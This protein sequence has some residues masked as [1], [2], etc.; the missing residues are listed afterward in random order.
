MK[1]FIFKITFI[2]FFF[3]ISNAQCADYFTSQIYNNNGAHKTNSTFTILEKLPGYN[4]EAAKKKQ[5][6][7][8]IFIIIN[9]QQDPCGEK[10]TGEESDELF[11]RQLTGIHRTGG[12]S[13]QVYLPHI[14]NSLAGTL[15]D[16]YNDNSIIVDVLNPKYNWEHAD[17]LKKQTEF[18]LRDIIHQ[19]LQNKS[20]KVNLFITGFSRG[21]L[22]S[23]KLAQ[24]LKNE[25]NIKA[26]VTIDPVINPLSTDKKNIAVTAHYKPRYKKWE[27]TNRKLLSWIKPLHYF[28]VLKNP[29]VP[30]YN[31]FQRHGLFSFGG[32]QFGRPVGSAIEGAL[33]PCK[34]D[35]ICALFYGDVSKHGPF[36]QYDS[37]VAY[38]S[39]DMPQKY[40]KWALGI[41]LKTMPLPEVIK[42]VV[43][44]KP[45]KPII[46][47]IYGRTSLYTGGKLRLYWRPNQGGLEYQH[48]TTRIGQQDD[49]SDWRE[50]EYSYTYDMY[51]KGHYI[52]KVRARNKIGNISPIKTIMIKIKPRPPYF[53]YLRAS[54]R[55]G[56]PGMTIVFDWKASPDDISYKIKFSQ[57]GKSLL[58][59]EK[60]YKK[61]SYSTTLYDQGDYVFSIQA[62]TKEGT[63][64]RRYTRALTI[65]DYIYPDEV[66]IGEAP[67]NSPS[68]P[69]NPKY[70]SGTYAVAKLAHLPKET[71]D[72]Y[73]EG[74]YSMNTP[75]WERDKIVRGLWVITKSMPARKENLKIGQTIVY[76]G[77]NPAEASDVRGATMSL[78]FIDDLSQI[79]NNIVSAS[80]PNIDDPS[81]LDKKK[82]YLHNIRVCIEPKNCLPDTRLPIS[83]PKWSEL[84]L[85][86]YKGYLFN[87]SSTLKSLKT[88]HLFDQKLNTCWAEDANDSGIGEVINFSI[89][90]KTVKLNIANGYQK[91]EKLFYANNR[92]K[93]IKYQVLLGINQEGEVSETKSLCHTIALNK[94]Q[95]VSLEDKMGVQSVNLK[96]NWD[97]IK[98]QA[99]AFIRRYESKH[100]GKSNKTYILQCTLVD[101]YKGNKYNDTCISEI[102]RAPLHP[103]I[104]NIYINEKE[105]GLLIDTDIKKGIVLEQSPS[106]VLQ[107]IDTS[108]DKQWV[109]VLSMPSNISNSRTET[110]Y[111]LYNT[112][113]KKKFTS[114]Q[115][116][117]DVGELYDFE[118]KDNKLLLNYLNTSMGEIEGKI[119]NEEL[120]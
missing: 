54:A 13:Y 78:A 102:Q 114:T 53:S 4:L 84:L 1:F 14:H 36:D 112:W 83:I 73:C 90:E 32:G 59:D 70:F 21:A 41:A 110:H 11:G 77:W 98:T 94:E 106:D 95:F 37:S 26:L 18:Y 56:T 7:E 120:N 40:A 68:D 88:L 2:S 22:L 6:V 105:N 29:H 31:V 71:Q 87:A 85:Q 97:M 47:R 107:I 23:Y 116:G 66:L 33:S 51:D 74:Y 96:L 25:A 49:W 80:W 30:T 64:S 9:G 101:V 92:V 17:K 8:N 118:Y 111:T 35:D 45:P 20:T 103:I 82:L 100:N 34:T 42:P 62:F 38:H 93:Q 108:K 67:F 75:D 63:Q 79:D 58:V 86:D 99:E 65:T 104:Q 76:S 46:K 55:V 60:E 57:K 119:I 69:Y 48:T 12:G 72:S 24:D 44:A 15:Y 50:N 39:P 28:P 43:I 10:C 61:D 117:V 3:L 16:Q 113:T 81:R 52:F 19:L 5:N 115:L 89:A 91:S 109:I 27:L